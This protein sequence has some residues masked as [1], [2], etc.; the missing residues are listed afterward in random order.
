MGNLVKSHEV[1]AESI[2]MKWE[3]K[4]KKRINPLTLCGGSVMLL[5]FIMSI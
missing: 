4:V 5:W 1:N 2:I 3:A